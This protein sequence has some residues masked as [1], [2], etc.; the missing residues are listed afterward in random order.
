MNFITEEL[1]SYSSDCLWEIK[2]KKTKVYLII[3]IEFQSAVHNFMQLRFLNYITQIYLKLVKQN[4][5]MK[6][7]PFIFPVL[8]YT[9]NKEWK[10]SNRFHDLIDINYESV[11]KYIPNFEYFNFNVSKQNLN[12]LKEMDSILSQL[13]AIDLEENIEEYNDFLQKIRVISEKLLK[14]EQRDVLFKEISLYL[15][16]KA[17]NYLDLN[18]EEIEDILNGGDTMIAKGL[19][20]VI[21]RSK[22]EGFEEGAYLEKIQIAKELL[23]NGTNTVFVAKITKLSIEEIEKLK[24]EMES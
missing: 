24:K 7:L 14:K 17:E 22:K 8:F 18:V 12:N 13:L 9:G 5:P 3:L 19:K 16:H 4:K 21:E 11:K 1:K 6:S 20:K 10:K 2:Y 15:Q 23:L